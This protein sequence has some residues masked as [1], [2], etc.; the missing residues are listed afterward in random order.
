MTDFV[1]VDFERRQVVDEARSWIGTPFHSG[2]QVKAGGVDCARLLAAAFRSVVRV[3]VPAYP[4]D[5]FLHTDRERLLEVVVPLC[6]KVASPEL[7]D[8]ALFKFGRCVSHG[9]IVVETSPSLLMVH[10]YRPSKGVQV[11]D[12]DVGS[13]LRSRLV[14]FWRLHRWQER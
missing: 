3:D 7:G 5:W 4:A 6:S 8:I 2:A 11:D 1:Q 14:G 12:I 13:G 10:A 9:G